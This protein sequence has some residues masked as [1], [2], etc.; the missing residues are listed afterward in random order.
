MRKLKL[1]SLFLMLLVGIG[2][3][4]GAETQ[5]TVSTNP[6]TSGTFTIS[7]AKSSGS[8]APIVP[9]GTTYV[10]CYANNV[11]TISTSGSA[12]M[13]GMTIAWTKNGSKAFASVTASTGD[14]THPT[15]AGNGTWSGK[16]K[17]VDFT[18][19]SSG[20]IQITSVTITTEDGGTPQPTPSLDHIAITG[21]PSNTSYE[22]GQS[23]DPAGLTVT[24]YYDD[25]SN[26][27]VTEDVEWSFDPATFTVAGENKSVTA[28]ATYQ[29]KEASETYN[30]ITVNEHVV[31]PGTYDITLNNVLFGTSVN[32][33]I[34]KEET[35]S[36]N[37][38]TLKITG[39][40]STKPRTDATY[41]RFY[42][43]SSLTL[44][45]PDGYN[46]T[47]IKITKNESDYSAPTVT[48]G[49]FNTSTKTW[50]GKA[51]EVVLSFSA[52][53]FIDDIKVTYEATVPTV[54]VDPEE[55]SFDAKQN[56]AVAGKT[57]KLTGANLTS[58]LT[59][60][61]SAGYSVSPTSLTAEA[62]MAQG[63]VEVTVTPA[64][65]TATTTPVEGT[66][67]ISGGG[68]AADVVVNLSM[69]VTPTYAV[70]LAVND[71]A[72][73]SATINGGAGPVYAEYAE[74]VT[75]VATAN[76]GY[77]FVNW[78]VSTEDIDLGEDAE[79]ANGAVAA[80]GAAGTITAN[81]QAQAC[82]GLNAPTLGE[83]TKTYN[84]AT[85]AWVA[86]A[87]ASQGYEVHVYSDN[88]KTDEVASDL[89]T[90][91]TSFN[92]ADLD[93]NTTYYFTIMGIGDGTSYCDEN[94]TLREGNF[95]TSDYPS[96]AVTYSENNNSVSGGSKKIMTPFALPTEVTNNISG[97]TFVGWTTKSDF[98]DGDESD[99]ETYFAK[100]ANFTIQSNAAVT[101][102]A[103][104][105]TAGSG[106]VTISSTPLTSAPEQG[107][108]YVIGANHKTAGIK[109]FST[110][111]GTGS[112]LSWGTMN[113]S[114]TI[115]FTLS[116]T[117]S[118][119]TAYDGSA[120]LKNRSGGFE[121]STTSTTIA[122]QAD[123]A[124]RGSSEETATRLR[125][126]SEQDTYGLRWYASDKSTGNP[127][128]FYKVEQNVSYSDYVISGSVALPV[129]A[130]P[131]FPVAEGVFYESTDITISAADGASIYYTTDGTTPSSTNGTLYEGA[132]ALNAYG[133]YN[134]KAIAVEADHEDSEV[135]EATYYLGKT[136]ASVSD[137][138]TYLSENSLTELN[139]VKVTGVVSRIK[140]IDP[141]KYVNGQ[142]YISVNGQESNEL[143]IYNGKYIN[144]ADFTTDPA[145]PL[146]VGDQVTI[147]GNYSLNNETHQLNAGNSIVARTA[148]ELASVA[149][150]GEL[151][152]KNYSPEDNVFNRTGLTATATYNTGYE[153]DVTADATWTNNLTNNIV[154]ASGNVEVTAT[155]GEKSDTKQVAVTYTSKTLD[156]ITLS[157]SS[158]TAYVGM[159]L[160]TPT[161]TASYVEEIDDEDV[162]A[163]VAAANG[164][165]TESAYNGNVAGSY[166]IKVSYTLGEVTDEKTYTVTVKAIYNNDAAPHNVAEALDIIGK[167]HTTTTASTDSIVV[168]GIVSR[169]DE[170]YYNTYWISDDGTKNDELE[171]YSG[172]YL[173]KATFTEANQLH[174]GDEVVV[175]GKVKTYK[176]TKEFDSNSRLISVLREP[177][178][179]IANIVAADEFEANVSEDMAVVPTANSGDVEF[180]LTSGNKAVVT[181]VENK[182]HAVAEG[183]AVITAHRDATANKNALNY[184]EA[185]TTFNV[186]VIAERTRYTVSFDK[187]GGEG[188]DPEA[189]AAQLAGAMVDMPAAC[190]Y[191]YDGYGFTGWKVINLST[192]AEIDVENDQFEMPA[193]NVKIQAQWAVVA[194]CR[195]SFQVNGEEVAH[196]NAPQEADY[197]IPANTTHP[198]V[199]GFT[200]LGWSETEYADEVETA[201]TLINVYHAQAGE[202]TKT[203]YGI[204]RRVEGAGETNHYVLDYTQETALSS[205]SSWGSYGKAFSYTATDGSEW[206][207]KAYKNAGMQMNTGKDASVKIPTCPG[208]IVSIAITCSAAKA[209]GL[210]AADYSGSGAI[211]YIVYG[212]DATSQTLD[213]SDETV[214]GGYIVPK[215]GSTSITKIDVTYSAEVTYYT[216]SPVEKVMITFDAN[217]GTGGCQK[218]IINKGSEL[219][220][221]AEAPTKLHSEFLGW[222][223][224]DDEYVAGQAYTFDADITLTA[225]WEDAATY[226]VTYNVNGSS[227]AAPTQEAQYAGDQFEVGAAVTKEGFTF[228]GWKYGSKLY[229]AGASFTMPAEAVEFVAQWRKAS[230]PVD[231]MSMITDVSALSNGMQIVIAQNVEASAE[232]C[233][234]MSSQ[235]NNN[236]SAVACNIA[237]N[238]LSVTN[239]VSL[240]TLI[241]L[242]DNKYAFKTSDNKYLYA[243]SSGSNH[244]KEQDNLNDNAKWTITIA[245]G[246][247]TI[248]AQGDNTHNWMRYNSG[249]SLFSCYAD[250]Q[251]DIS[252]FGKAVVVTDDASISDLGYT[253]GEAIIASGEGVTLT[254]DEPTTVPS[255]TAQ[256]G[257]TV[258][259]DKQTT[260]ESVVVEDGSKI[261]ANAATTTPTVYF[262]TS[263]GSTQVPGSA[264]QLDQ[265]E[266]ITLATGG[267][268]VYD[269]T[270][271]VDM[272]TPAGA[273]KAANQW[274]AFTIPFPVDAINGIYNAANDEKLSNEVDY[275]IM[276]YHGDIRA[277]GLYGWKKYTGTLQPGV[278]YLMTVNGD[279][280][281][282]RFKAAKTGAMTQTTSMNITA[283]NGTSTDNSDKGWNG[284]GNPSWVSGKIAKDV[285]VLDPYSYEYKLRNASEWNFSVSTPFFYFDNAK[286][287]ATSVVSM[288]AADAENNYAPRR[289]QANEIKN[290]EVSFGNE[291]YTDQFYI[292]AS[293]D[294]LNEFE[295]D[296]D[297]Y[298][299]RMSNTPKVAQIM[300]N[301]YG[302]QMA[303]IYAPMANDQAEY[304]LTLY[305][306][307][308]GEYTISAQEMEDADLYLTQNGSII[309]NLSM[310]E[311]VADFA[312][313]NNEGY[314]L[315]LI[316]KAPGIATG[317]DEISGEKAGV[318]KIVL[319]DKVFILR[320]GKMYDVTGKMVK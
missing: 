80:I 152:K 73:G 54:T 226:D 62:A 91:G 170:N 173:N 245:G 249:S 79:K 58:G 295:Q 183:D 189:I 39:T 156:H 140:S 229:K 122:L 26:A 18:V 144:G 17:S 269:L 190:P 153:K 237:N 55:L 42:S 320:G 234:V 281:T 313:G 195:I 264:T 139:N 204:Y 6:T 148:A 164:F 161:V 37:D 137:L 56:I 61:A 1:F 230:V 304:S 180:T 27:E 250:G 290:V 208:N 312:K 302:K 23:F 11:I 251:G 301:A 141:S 181:I 166:I 192:E 136:F 163:L 63:G 284:I 129:L 217:G 293:E 297:Q 103:V 162:T 261:V 145:C 289:I 52:K 196:A 151:E 303:K 7:A 57:F 207:V 202:E 40:G 171:V 158:T 317:V 119:L 113:A 2:Q 59:L 182:L 78:T 265:V 75:L 200:F 88:E 191:N 96:V 25:D 110:Y 127:A 271:G 283:F 33:N 147:I 212:T 278:F 101:L 111:S 105:A 28:T 138:Y 90:S 227:D 215:S 213:L 14:Y 50:T 44:S 9:S 206:V 46:L 308:A 273:E 220:I 268:I 115:Y 35:G 150:G 117:T 41:V 123:G 185:T 194:T 97:K 87:N 64:T 285:Y 104:Y 287:D 66:V 99:E 267:E 315:L 193:A 216:S 125:Y 291:V 211:S 108:Q 132:I 86:L 294:A 198:T 72:M 236:R 128:Y 8:N 29:E 252:L 175:K 266:N 209:V 10:R 36:Q 120:Y 201:P 199:D 214:T 248:I 223:N 106:D 116:G 176:S 210:S 298:K 95:T 48:V 134:F 12:N 43:S 4:W 239:E 221:C 218:A 272:S 257:A 205:S 240:F 232:T 133:T 109:Y 243:A 157:Y 76:P 22:Q 184:K 19:G 219:T 34:T 300:G 288:D 260:A 146:N 319:E 135:A 286:T 168:A 259:I 296:Q 92:V 258:V 222:K 65:P 242:D 224:G 31:T 275:A 306:P 15:A 24:A 179:A 45:V 277:N 154:A 174:V 82:T 114:T 126:N 169:L 53:S 47:E 316:K 309:W 68:L 89:V 276:D 311:Y 20:Q 318:Q 177:E 60:A 310:S 247:A 5:I 85:I 279:V 112:N 165:D 305:A 256:N 84:S 225:Q 121:M 197:N 228:Q 244:L 299:L 159:A 49:S 32:A 100:G 255:I 187:N 270:L 69:A 94:N 178:F 98:E 70:A 155:Y 282:F 167:Y 274:H 246:V 263:M 231:K 149:I 307:N 238:I 3:M 67:T 51:Q 93:A 262:S 280:Q 186:H 253:E 71:N 118:A 13:T 131:T 130:A 235:N 143:Y 107:A 142:Y 292:S 188:S 30:D 160:P 102:Y 83:I 81:F 254:I 124:I 16:A 21:T 77:E 233:K 172:K 314:G 203:L 38:I 241:A 74:N